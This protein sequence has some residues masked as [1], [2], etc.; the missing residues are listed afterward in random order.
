MKPV[1][2]GIVS[3]VVAL[4]CGCGAG[5]YGFA[6]V[7][8][9]SEVEKPYHDRSRGY[10]FGIVAAKPHEFQG[11]LIAWFGIVKSVKQTEDG[12]Y[13]IRMSHNTHRERHLCDGET[14]SSCRVT[15]HFK[16]TGEFS[17]LLHIDQKDLVPSLDKIQPGTLLRVFGSVRCATDD[18]G[19]PTCEFDENGGLVL[20]GEFYRQWPARYYVTTRAM[21]TMRR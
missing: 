6:R 21:S 15:V 18:E 1:Y 17:A 14:N 2:F 7:Y 9:P 12:R 4:L 16:S 13:W 20:E 11:Q 19:K 5:P 8:E 10:P 3:L